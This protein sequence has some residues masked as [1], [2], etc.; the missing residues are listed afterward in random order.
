MVRSTRKVTACVVLAA[1]LARGLSPA[2]DSCRG[3]FAELLPR[4]APDGFADEIGD[5]AKKRD[6]ASYDFAKE[7]DWNNGILLPPPGKFQPLQALKA[8]HKM[9]L[10]LHVTWSFNLQQVLAGDRRIAGSRHIRG[11]QLRIEM[12]G[13]VDPKLLTA[14]E[15]HRK[16]A[17]SMYTHAFNS[18]SG[19]DG[20]GSRADWDVVKGGADS[21][22]AYE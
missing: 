12:G 16:G 21:E 9:M 1:V 13:A 3:R 20:V 15:A 11:E 17:W 10:C 6:D 8:I 7:V 4:L 19:P 2:L 14:A 5:A 18:I 22:K